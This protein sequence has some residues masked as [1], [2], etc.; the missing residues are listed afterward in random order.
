M[1]EHTYTV[2]LRGDENEV[3]R[4]KI[5]TAE[6]HRYK[7]VADAASSAHRIHFQLLD[8]SDEVVFDACAHDVRY[9]EKE[10]EVV[11]DD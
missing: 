4:T 11:D 1:T 3:K 8:D 7:D 5:R 6:Y 9:W 2:V 10:G